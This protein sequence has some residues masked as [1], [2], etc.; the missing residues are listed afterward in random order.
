MDWGY[1]WWG[2][3]ADQAYWP[4]VAV[5]ATIQG[6]AMN[7]KPLEDQEGMVTLAVP[8]P[9]YGKDDELNAIAMI[10]FI[11]DHLENRCRLTKDQRSRVAR[12]V[13]NRYANEKETNK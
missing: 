3:I 4:H 1:I 10:W 5:E 7:T 8:M 2:W 6:D 11:I 13:A 9:F 12:W